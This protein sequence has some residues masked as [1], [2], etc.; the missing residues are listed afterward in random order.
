MSFWVSFVF[1]FGV[2]LGFLW[3]SFGFPFGFPLGVL[4]GLL[5]VS[6]VILSGALWIS[7]GFPVGFRWVSF[8]F[9]WDVRLVSWMSFGFPLGLNPSGVS[10]TTHSAH[11]KTQAFKCAKNEPRNYKNAA[12]IFRTIAETLSFYIFASFVCLYLLVVL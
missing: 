12:H 1:P 2:P 11:K 6:A 8:W 9:P 7:F 5:W 10:Y 3:I 4:W